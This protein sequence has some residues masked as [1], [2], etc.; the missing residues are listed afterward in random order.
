MFQLSSIKLFTT[1]IFLFFAMLAHAQKEDE[2]VRT[3]GS[4]PNSYFAIGNKA[5]FFANDGIHGTQP[6]IT[7][8]TTI[9]TKM[10][11]EILERKGVI[12]YGNPVLY[13]KKVYFIKYSSGKLELCATD[14]TAKGSKI[15]QKLPFH[16]T[17]EK[18]EVINNELY[19][20][21][22]L[23]N[24]YD[25][26]LNAIVYHLNYTSDTLNV[27]FSL[28]NKRF[29][30]FPSAVSSNKHQVYFTVRSDLVS[31]NQYLPN[32]QQELT[33]WCSNNKEYPVFIDSVNVRMLDPL[34]VFYMCNN[35]LVY[36]KEIML[37]S[38]LKSIRVTCIAK[39]LPN[40]VSKLK[41]SDGSDVLFPNAVLPFKQGFVLGYADTSCKKPCN[42]A[43]YCNL[44]TN[45]LTPLQQDTLQW[46]K[47]FYS[48]WATDSIAYFKYKSPL[49]GR[50][51]FPYGLWCTDGTATGTQYLKNIDAI[52]DNAQSVLWSK[53]SN[54]IVFIG[55]NATTGIELWQTQGSPSSTQQLIDLDQ[56]YMYLNY[57]FLTPLNKK[58]L[59]TYDHS[60]Y[61]REIWISDLTQKGTFMLKD[62]NKQKVFR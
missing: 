40:T 52:G 6:W 58:L 22:Y 61:G 27:L 45:T 32:K 25:T 3:K 33:L 50:A 47:D 51:K 55:A 35:Q 54:R 17:P 44:A 13:N 42:F 15:I 8:G 9:G 7:D 57:F 10:I 26:T 53:V 38:F 19:L 60:Q 24:P 31:G 29:K 56:Q 49:I 28:K 37:D 1:L 5:I 30:N 36:S 21:G 23:Y 12:T 46:P 48:L 34:D 2:L 11:A 39:G 14:G 43:A 41:H 62:I 20:M 4:N 18:A 16:F 59:F